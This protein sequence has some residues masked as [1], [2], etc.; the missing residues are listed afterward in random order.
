[1]PTAVTR[2]VTSPTRTAKNQ[3]W[4]MCRTRALQ[5][6]AVAMYP[7]VRTIAPVSCRRV[8]RGRR[9]AAWSNFAASAN[10]EYLPGRDERA[11]CDR[12][13]ETHNSIKAGAESNPAYR[14]E[15]SLPGQRIMILPV[16]CPLQ[17]NGDGKASR[18]S[19]CQSKEEAKADTV[20]Q[21]END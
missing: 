9:F 8:R 10:G 6:S 3:A 14:T 2:P 1:M 4:S 12:E 20:A 13:R 11:E 7:T 21:S 16:R 17:L 18:G 15:K 5:T 19:G